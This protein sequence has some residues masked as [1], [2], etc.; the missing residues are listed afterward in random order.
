MLFFLYSC[1]SSNYCKDEKKK[2]RGHIHWQPVSPL[3]VLLF[4]TSRRHRA[5]TSL[6]YFDC[7]TP[8]IPKPTTSV[9]F[10]ANIQPPLLVCYIN[11]PFALHPSCLRRLQTSPDRDCPYSGIVRCLAKANPTPDCPFWYIYRHNAETPRLAKAGSR[12]LVNIGKAKFSLVHKHRATCGSTLSV[13]VCPKQVHPPPFLLPG[14]T[15][16]SFPLC[17]AMSLPRP[18]QRQ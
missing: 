1:N 3:I 4:M 9:M 14:P 12:L 11:I 7:M 16:L 15:S 6:F 13:P 5:F 8:L 2:A 10:L 18:R 17:K